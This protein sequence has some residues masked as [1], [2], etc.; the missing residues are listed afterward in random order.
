MYCLECH[1]LIVKKTTYL[2]IFKKSYDLICNTCFTKY[3]FIQKLEVLPLD[4]GTL[5]LNILFDQIKSPFSLM[6]TVKAYYLYYLKKKTFNIILYFDSFDEKVY[7][8]L[9]NIGFGD[10][11]MI[12][13]QTKKR[14]K[15]YED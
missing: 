3:L 13:L 5:Y 11:F 6:N 9:Q 2:N 7:N 8:D 12:V 15:D 1:K 14:R 4:G 10:I